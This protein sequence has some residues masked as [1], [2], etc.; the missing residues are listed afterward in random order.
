MAGV[1]ILISGCMLFV[2]MRWENY[3]TDNVLNSI[4]M[5]MALSVGLYGHYWPKKW[6]F[7]LYLICLVFY[8][9][10]FSASYQSFLIDVLT[11]PRR[12]PQ[13]DSLAKAVTEEFS[14]TGPD[15]VR[16]Y[17]NGDSEA[18]EYLRENY[19][20]CY[21]YDECLFDIK[22]NDKL[23]VAIS[24]VHALNVPLPINEEHMYCF[25]RG[26]NIHTYSVVM[27]VMKDYFLLPRM[28][29]LIRRMTETGFMLKWQYDAEL[30]KVI[31]NSKLARESGVTNEKVKLSIGHLAG[32]F[33]LCIFGLIFSSLG[34]AFEWI[35]WHLANNKKKKVAIAIEKYI[36]ENF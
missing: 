6:G 33:Y 8:G 29:T 11:N 36:M 7:R 25:H 17:F 9:M 2:C 19:G 34:F 12:N 14:F 15:S 30:F 5:A 27:L 1:T 10:N 13:V 16:Y 22:S 3:N 21:N 24:R 20:I 26:T 4:F 23:A 28:N 32:A 35:I 18:M 31:Q